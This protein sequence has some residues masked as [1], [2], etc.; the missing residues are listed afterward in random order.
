MAQATTKRRAKQPRRTDRAPRPA[1]EP[2]RAETAEPTLLARPATATPPPAGHCPE[3]L[4]APAKGVMRVWLM[5]DEEGYRLRLV[6]VGPDGCGWEVAKWSDGTR[7]HLAE[8]DGGV[9]TCDCPGATAHGPHCN[10]G[11]GCKHARMLHEGRGRGRAH[12]AGGAGERPG[13]YANL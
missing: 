8:A 2:T 10:G 6:H 13:L 3:A 9:I 4:L 11:K 12:P 7:Y 1:A 5:T